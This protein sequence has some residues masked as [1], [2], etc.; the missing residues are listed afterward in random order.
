MTAISFTRAARAALLMLAIACAKKEAEPV[1]DTMTPAPAPAPAPTVSTIEL[2]RHI[3]PD[4]RVTDTASVFA[5]RD[6]VY[7]AVVTNN[8]TPT[9]NVTAKW[10]FQDGQ[11]VDSTMQVVAPST[12]ADAAAVTEFHIV[13]PSGWPVG[14]YKV[15]V[16]LDGQ[17]AGSR[18]FEVKR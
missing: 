3:G 13:K 12:T 8:T 7:L 9:S 5:P 14:K 6:T 15:D 18:E 16:L 11:V 1:P 17:P 4:K 2:G 10:S